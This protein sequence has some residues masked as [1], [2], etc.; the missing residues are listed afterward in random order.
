VSCLEKEGRHIQELD[1]KEGGRLRGVVLRQAGKEPGEQGC[2]RTK[3]DRAAK[4]TRAL[5]AQLH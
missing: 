5:A 3:V 4:H 2:L 1:D